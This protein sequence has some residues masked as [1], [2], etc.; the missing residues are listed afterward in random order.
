MRYWGSHCHK[1]AENKTRT[2][3]EKSADYK[4][5]AEVQIA[6][7]LDREGIAYQYEHPLA[8]IDRGRIRV[9]YPDFRLPEYGMILE[10]FGLNGD[11][12]YRQRTE[13][14]L[15]VYRANGVE[16][17]FLR[18]ESFRG[19]WPGRVLEQIEDVL[20]RRYDGF[21]RRRGDR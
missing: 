21:Y 6:R 7:L 13:H 16:G 19:D 15:Q 12:G 5:K 20:R 17:V 4:S 9:W 14:K 10:Y 1:M 3:E 11:L 18:P 2:S 8:V